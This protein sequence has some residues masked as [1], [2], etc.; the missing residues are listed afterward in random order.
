MG[1]HNLKERALEIGAKLLFKHKKGHTI[2]LSMPL[3]NIIDEG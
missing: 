1:R 3:G 2:N